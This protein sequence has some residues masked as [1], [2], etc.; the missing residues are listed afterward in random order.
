MFQGVNNKNR[1]CSPKIILK[2]K[3][4]TPKIFVTLSRNTYGS[5]H[6]GI[7]IKYYMGLS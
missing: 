4:K 2:K 5:T 1:H 3:K 7:D 6:Q